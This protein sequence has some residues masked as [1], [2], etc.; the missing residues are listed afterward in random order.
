M[1]VLNGGG[2]RDTSFQYD[3]PYFGQLFM[4]TIFRIIDYPDLL[5]HSSAPHDSHFIEM[6]YLV[7]R[8][9]M[10]IFAVV[11]TFLVYKISERRYVKNTNSKSL[12]LAIIS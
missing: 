2:P 8:I 1:I 4:A 12:L 11:D 6:V 5:V 3:H 7:P 9:L 10:G